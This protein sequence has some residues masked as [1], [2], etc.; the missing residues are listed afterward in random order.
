MKF[1]RFRAFRISAGLLVLFYDA[2]SA[3]THYVNVNNPAPLVP[4]TSW[5]TAAT[6]IQDAVNQTV[7]DDIILVTNGT[8]ILSQRITITRN[9]LIQSVNGKE[10]TI[11]D[12]GGK[13]RCFDL[14][15]SSCRIDGFS[16][17]N[18]YAVASWYADPENAGG[19][20]RCNDTTPIVMNC[21]FRNNRAGYGGGA[22]SGTASNCIFIGNSATY[23]GG[24]VCYGS[25]NNCVFINNSAGSGGGMST[26]GSGSGVANHCVFFENTASTSGG[27]MY[28]GNPTYCDFIRNSA[29]DGYSSGGGLCGG[30]D[31]VAM[32][33]TFRGNS[34]G[35]G[36]GMY[37]GTGNSCVFYG[38]NAYKNGGGAYSG[39]V[40]NCTVIENS[41][42]KLGGGTGS[43][44]ANNSVIWSNTAGSSGNNFDQT[45]LHYSCSPDVIN[46]VD[47]NI[48]NEPNFALAYYL[49]ENSPCIDAGENSLALTA[50]DRDGNGRI[51]GA[52]VDMGAYEWMTRPR[53]ACSSPSIIKLRAEKTDLPDNIDTQVWNVGSSNLVYT[54]QEG[55]DWLKMSP[56]TG[57][58]TGDI[59]TLTLQFDIDELPAGIYWDKVRI[60]ASDA[61][62]NPQEIGVVLEVYDPVLDHFEF[63]TVP[64]PQAAGV[65]FPLLVYAKDATNGTIRTY[66][67]AAN[68]TATTNQ[69]SAPTNLLSKTTWD[70][71]TSDNNVVRGLRF[72]P[73]SDIILTHLRRYFGSK[74]SVWTDNGILLVSKNIDEVRQVW[75][76][77]KLDVPIRLYSG[78]TYRI[79][80][81]TGASSYMG[82]FGTG[83]GTPLSFPHGTINQGCSGA[84]DVFPSSTTSTRYLVDF[85]YQAV[86]STQIAI[87]AT[88]SDVFKKGVRSSVVTIN[89]KATN[90]A[91]VARND[92]GQIGESSMFDVI[93]D[94]DCDGLH[95][96]WEVSYFGSVTN[97]LPLLDADGD[98]FSNLDEFI[99]DTDPT[100][101]ASV[102]KI[103]SQSGSAGYGIKWNAIS[104]RVYAVS[105]STNLLNGFQSLETNIPWTRGSFSN[106]MGFPCVYY[107]L[108]VRME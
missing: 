105:F 66:T 100:N 59:D 87:S 61:S 72:T 4:Y 38:N 3:D 68:L 14:G 79:G 11:V 16:I 9:I 25:A 24:G 48:T 99:S 15:S 18:G 83:S 92:S 90:V 73:S 29:S 26:G 43:C 103:Y 89:T 104:G 5:A 12:G 107:K 33:C 102:L 64:S 70:S 17:V 50:A 54:V 91:V 37:G 80:A 86:S 42:I 23:H 77:I 81:F 47:G 1:M 75:T 71:G 108:N 21:I 2:V 32:Y 27:G 88:S 36:G 39:T 20:V 95:D 78:H 31:S 45:I 34:A 84:G 10:V 40:N 41:S 30:A 94:T 56:A 97:C 52:Q 28:A 46:G 57:L 85:R 6:N 19:G 49:G 69:F 76:E 62:N 60:Q 65:S 98:G 13:T 8:Y 53:I 106:S 74:V 44:S 22:S 55:T 93:F 58:S 82:N 96:C 101:S 7:N 63:A 67:G 51:S 35:Y